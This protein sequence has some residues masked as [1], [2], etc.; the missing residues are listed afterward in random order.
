M[1][2]TS[3]HLQSLTLLMGAKYP[4]LGQPDSNRRMQESKTCALPLGNSPMK[5]LFEYFGENQ[6]G[7]LDEMKRICYHDVEISVFTDFS[8]SRRGDIAS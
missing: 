5:S 4:E 7:N 6:T 2:S 1:R 8:F 3:E